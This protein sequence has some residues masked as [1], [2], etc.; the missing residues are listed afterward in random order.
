MVE[1]PWRG[2]TGQDPYDY[3]FPLRYSRG[4]ILD[5]QGNSRESAGWLGSI[6]ESMIAGILYLGPSLERL[7]AQARRGG[8]A[9]AEV[10]NLRLLVRLWHDAD[11]EIQSRVAAARTRLAEL[12]TR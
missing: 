8:D 5:G 3:P 2:D 11:P 1:E 9:A 12:A 4:A 7:A 10:A 6:D